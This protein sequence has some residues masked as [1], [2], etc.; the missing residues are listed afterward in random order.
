MTTE[1]HHAKITLSVPFTIKQEGAWYICSCH[2]LDVHS[3]GQTIDEAKRNFETTLSL[4]VDGC[5]EMGTLET[6]LRDCGFKPD[7]DVHDETTDASM[8]N[9]PIHLLSS[10]SV[11]NAAQNRTH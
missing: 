8:I 5:L 7:H 3:Q 1:T 2:V 9:I 10:M 6:V 11:G 4:F